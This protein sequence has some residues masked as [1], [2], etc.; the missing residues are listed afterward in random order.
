MKIK[1]I[2]CH[3]VYNYGASLQAYALMK[4]LQNQEHEVEIID[5]KPE[6][7]CGRYNFWHINPESKY[8]N[9]CKKNKF[10]HFLYG[11]KNLKDTFRTFKRK[12]KFDLFKKEYL[13]VTSNAYHSNEELKNNI[14]DADLYIAGSDQIWN[15]SSCNG[16]DPTFYLDFI[17]DKAKKATYA[18]SF[19][20]SQIQEEWRSFVK[21]MIQNIGHV[22]VREETG[23]K[24]L[25]DLGLNGEVVLDPVFLLDKKEWTNLICNQYSEKYLLVY[26]FLH[27]DSELETLAITIARKNNWKIYSINDYNPIG[28]ANKNISNA[29]PIEFLEY[30][31]SAQ[32]IISSSFH[33][34]AFSI[35]LNK[36]FYVFKLKG[37]TNSSR[38]TDLLSK[39]N[40]LNRF[41]TKKQDSSMQEIKYQEV[42][43]ILIKERSKSYQ[44]FSEVYSSIY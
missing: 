15:T 34:T 13:S 4:Y 30:I 18:A 28:Y 35:L 24:I 19:G 9:L 33:A 39:L 27:N 26:D 42:N 44:Y 38:I 29:G 16:K 12:K 43:A 14:P 8:Y 3:D 1:T 21:A 25:E 17:Q 20:I 23:L 5:Y 2:T 36:E 32:M 40:I 22:S 37:Y 31:N 7:L 41:I 6:Y 10:V 11:I